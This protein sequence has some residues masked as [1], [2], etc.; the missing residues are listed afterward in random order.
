LPDGKTLPGELALPL[1][2]EPA[3][4]ELE[5]GVVTGDVRCQ[6]RVTLGVGGFFSLLLAPA[7]STSHTLPRSPWNDQQPCD[8]ATAPRDQA[9]GCRD[10]ARRAELANRALQ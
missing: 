9:Q 5:N 7:A 8:G 10:T 1:P 4:V 6:W 3:L 2:L